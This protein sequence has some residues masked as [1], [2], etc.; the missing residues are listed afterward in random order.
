MSEALPATAPNCYYDKQMSHRGAVNGTDIDADSGKPTSVI[1]GLGLQSLLG[2]ASAWTFTDYLYPRLA[3]I[4]GTDS[5]FVSATPVFLAKSETTNAIATDFTVGT[6][7]GVN[8]SSDKPA[9]AISAGSGTITPPGS[10][11]TLTATKTQT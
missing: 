10:D 8:W 3:D 5:A 9:I 4:D 7:N 1:T 6:G 2:T 11:V